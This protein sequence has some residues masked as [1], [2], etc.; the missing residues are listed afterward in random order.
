MLKALLATFA[1]IL[2]LGTP[3]LAHNAQEALGPSPVS[4]K[5]PNVIFIL[6]EDQDLHMDSGYEKFVQ[7]GL[8]SAYL[9]VWLQSAGYLTYY[10]GKLFNSHTLDNYNNPF[11]SSWTGSDFLL[12]PYN[13]SYLNST[14]QRNQDPPKSYEGHYSV[15]VLADIVWG[16]L[17]DAVAAAQPFFLAAASVA[18]HSNIDAIPSNS[19]DTLNG[20]QL[21]TPP[22]AAKRHKHLFPDAKVPRHANFNPDEPSGINWIHAPPPSPQNTTNIAFNDHFYR[23]R[24]RSLQSVDEFVATLIFTLSHHNLLENTYIIYTTDNGYSIGQHRRQP[25]KECGYEEDVNVPLIIRGPGLPRGEA[26]EVVTAHTDLVPTVFEMVGLVPHADFDGVKIT[27]TREGLRVTEGKGEQGKKGGR[28]EHVGV[29]YWGCAVSEGKYGREMHLYHT[30]KAL[31]VRGEGYDFYYA[32]WCDG[33]CEVYDMVTRAIPGRCTTSIPPVDLISYPL[34]KVLNRL[35]SLL[36]FLESC[37]GR[38][39]THP[40]ETLYPTG[41]VRNLHDALYAKFDDYYEAQVERVR[42]D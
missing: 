30:Y 28:H 9:P 19:K 22:I 26:S 33:G 11:S 8:N 34:P 20:S 7:E 41:N 25:G 18:P 42:F 36:L 39:C 15:D 14:Y 21:T 23:Q 5:P 2:A 35:D 4:S 6:T 1:G 37:K 32:V 40:W 24:L 12:D 10:V 17:D 13:Y 29:E 16:F 31:R 38:A 3:V 27:L